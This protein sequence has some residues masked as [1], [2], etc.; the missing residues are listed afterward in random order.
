MKNINLHKAI[1]QNID[2]PQDPNK[3]STDYVF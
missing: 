2:Q 1:D 3:V